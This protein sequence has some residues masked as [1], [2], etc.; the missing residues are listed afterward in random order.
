MSRAKTQVTVIGECM[1]EINGAPFGILHQAF[2]GD[3]LN[4]ALYLARLAP[5]SVH[6]QYVTAMGTDVLSEGIVQCWR[7]EGIDTTRVLRDPTRLPGLYWIAVDQHGER[8]FRYWRGQSP[9]RYWL[10]HPDCE[11]ALRTLAESDLIYLS[12]V[13]LAI[14]PEDDRAK[15]LSLLAELAMR[16]IAIAFDSNYRPALW[17]S[18]ETARVAM[19]ALLPAVRLIFASFDD[20]RALW[21]DAA[22]QATLARLVREDRTVVVKLGTAGCLYGDG[23]TTIEVPALPAPSVVDT[24]AAGDAFNAGFFAARVSGHGP[25]ECCSVGHALANVVIQHWGAIIPANATPVLDALLG[26]VSCAGVV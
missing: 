13:S 9:A 26:R 24:T 6:V 20:E 8:T 22:P 3:T 7:S 15:L 12:S 23:K 14:L 21:G 11:R 17:P 16:G 1:I 5:G 18:L 2:G 4:T 10:R 19:N 25:W